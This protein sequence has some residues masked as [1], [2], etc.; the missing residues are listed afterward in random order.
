MRK[1]TEIIIHCTATPKGKK[2]TIEDIRH[3]HIHKNGWKDIGYHYVI[4]TDGKIHSGRNEEDIGAHCKGHNTNSI[5][6]AYVGGLAADGKMPADTRTDAQKSALLRLLKVLKAKYP[7]A[8]IHSHRDFAAKACPCFNATKEY[9]LLTLF[10]FF[11]LFFTACGSKKSALKEDFASEKQTGLSAIIQVRD[12]LITESLL[13]ADS[14]TLECRI[15]SIPVKITAHKPALQ[16]KSQK[17]GTTSSLQKISAT[18][19]SSSTTSL[20]QEK[21]A[22][23][24]VFH[25]AFLI[26]IIT[27][28]LAVTAFLYHRKNP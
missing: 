9:A 11:S 24:P 1:I 23:K 5:G 18:E 16:S 19:T 26:T 27:T 14:I 4:T 8:A 3:C 6:V 15:D 17:T 28:A 2:I 21:Q 7:K 10:L 13:T 22:A 20:Q 12:S 25:T